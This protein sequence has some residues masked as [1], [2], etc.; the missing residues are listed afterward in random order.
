MLMK[1]DNR[2]IPK[3]NILQWLGLGL[4]T[5]HSFVPDVAGDAVLVSCVDAA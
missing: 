2:P 1:L 5:C 3:R 4:S